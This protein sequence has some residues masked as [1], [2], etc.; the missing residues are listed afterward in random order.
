MSLPSGIPMRN[1]MMM[2]SMM[3]WE[4]PWTMA[5]MMNST[6][7]RMKTRFRPSGSAT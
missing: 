4:K 5:R 6:I 7:V 3:F 1:R 2:R